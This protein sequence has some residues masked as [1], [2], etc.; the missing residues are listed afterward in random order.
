MH[1]TE[2]PAQQNDPEH[3]DAQPEDFNEFDQ[4]SL[5]FGAQTSGQ[6]RNMQQVS[7]TF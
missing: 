3:F 5:D 1:G 6:W 7:I 2:A 4:N